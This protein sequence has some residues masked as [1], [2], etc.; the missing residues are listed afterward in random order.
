MAIQDEALGVARE[1]ERERVRERE[2][3]TQR[4]STRERP[5]GNFA[6]KPAAMRDKALGVG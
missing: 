1:G 6:G 5:E 4:E 3:A 2:R